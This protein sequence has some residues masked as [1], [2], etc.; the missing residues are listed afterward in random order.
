M[1]T[2][3]PIRIILVDDH[4]LTRN[5]LQQLLDN[6]QRFSVIAQCDNGIDAIEQ[7]HDLEPD[8]ILLDIN[9]SPLNGFQATK[10]IHAANPAI[11]II[12]ISAHNHPRYAST[13]MSL[14]AKG[15]VTKTSPFTELTQAIVE[16]H[17][18]QVYICEEIRLY[19]LR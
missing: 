19:M 5:S 8:I 16:V 12:G 1:T 13:I 14:G 10:R 15:F 18:G 3:H 6:D 7:A 11:N 9:M 17:G 2:E 4:E